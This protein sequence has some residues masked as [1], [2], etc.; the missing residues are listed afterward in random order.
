[1]KVLSLST[2][3]FSG[4]VFESSTDEKIE[5]IQEEFT[6]FITK[7]NEVEKFSICHCKFDCR[8]CYMEDILPLISKW[9]N[10][11]HLTV[12]QVK[13]LRTCQFLQ[14]IAGACPKLTSLDLIFIG[15]PR[16][17]HF[18][19]NLTYILAKS[20]E[21]KFLRINQPGLYPMHPH[22]WKHIHKARA[23]EGICLLTHLNTAIEN[24]TIVDAISKLP[25]L[26][27]FHL[28]SSTVGERFASAIKRVMVDNGVKQPDVK[29]KF[30]DSSFNN[31]RLTYLSNF[32][33][34]MRHLPLD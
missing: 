12:L 33:C 30:P 23:L 29:V 2:C 8:S 15:I 22:I 4:P 9:P 19:P 28:I 11:K 27:L 20:K 17:C 21:L 7:C 3:C 24:T 25:R 18:L 31:Q 6:T 32:T 34:K 14:S 13:E 1:L 10:L 5:E 26:H 16:V